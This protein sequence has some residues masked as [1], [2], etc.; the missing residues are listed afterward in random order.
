MIKTEVCEAAVLVY[1]F[2]CIIYNRNI[3]IS[4]ATSL[5]IALILP[6]GRS[7]NVASLLLIIVVYFGF[8]AH[9]F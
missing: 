6:T 9:F 4:A 8:E 3:N 7:L 2:C 5:M 1:V